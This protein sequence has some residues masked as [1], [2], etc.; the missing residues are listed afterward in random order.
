M[1]G[2]SPATDMRMQGYP[3]KVK[4]L[5][6]AS[7]CDFSSAPRRNPSSPPGH[8]PARD[9]RATTGAVRLGRRRPDDRRRRPRYLRIMLPVASTRARSSSEATCAG[10]P[11]C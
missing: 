4:S 10:E 9:P 6:W 5:A 7:D 8:S 3:A 11:Q 2:A 1:S